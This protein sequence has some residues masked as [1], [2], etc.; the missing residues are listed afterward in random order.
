MARLKIVPSLERASC[1][2]SREMV[3][4][5]YFSH[6]WYSGA[7]FSARLIGFGFS[8]A[9][10]RSWTVGEDIAYGSGSRGTA[11]AIFAAWMH[12]PPHRAI[13]LDRSFRSAGVG[14]AAARSRASPASCS[15]PSTAARARTEVTALAP[16]HSRSRP[17]GAHRRTASAPPDRERTARPQRTAR[18]RA[19]APPVTTSPFRRF[20]GKT[21]FAAYTAAGTTVTKEASRTRRNCR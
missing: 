8:P 16:G 21:L 7:S 14:R 19:S 20:A 5:G 3:S 18:S 1:S 17:G 4:R 9:G 15:L 13:I 11:A 6:S 12:S 2:H 10:Y